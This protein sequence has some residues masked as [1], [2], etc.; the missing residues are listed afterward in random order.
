LSGRGAEGQ[1]D[2]DFAAALDDGVTG[3]AV[4]ANRG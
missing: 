4:D 3:D 1:M 2:A